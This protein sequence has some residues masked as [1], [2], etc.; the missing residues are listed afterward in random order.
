MIFRENFIIIGSTGRN[1]G[2]TEF[3]CRLI[4]RYSAQQECYAVKVTSINRVEGKCPRGGDGC[5]VCSS[6]KDDFEILEEKTAGKVKDT[7]RLLASGAKRVFWLKVFTDSLQKGLDALLQYI[8]D[9]VPVVV[10]SN[11]LRNVLEPGLFIVIKNL[12]DKNVK[13][14]CAGVIHLASKIIEFDN[15]NWNFPPDRIIIKNNAWLIR[16][17]ATAIVLAGGK[18]SRMG[19]MD[20]SLLPIHGKPMIAQIISQLENHFDEIIVGANDREK[21][22]FLQLPVIPDIAPD[23]GPL[24]GILSCLKASSNDVNFITACDIPVMNL[25]LVHNM[26]RLSIDYD[27]VMPVSG[28]SHYEPLYAVYK[29]NVI[30]TAEAILKNNGRKIIELFNYSKVRFVDFENSNWYENLNRKDDYMNFIKAKDTTQC[31]RDLP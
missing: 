6:L 12:N 17:F 30:P 1:T 24:M 8:P 7:Q 31:Y 22:K 18:S 4:Q 25:K 11:R 19:G 10:E 23:K 28:E 5:G 20:K 15:M 27:I 16:E 2:K 9:H 21:Y 26:I 14:S 13:A 29:K 3:A